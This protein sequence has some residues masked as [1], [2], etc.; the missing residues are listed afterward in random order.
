MPAQLGQTSATV[1]GEHSFFSSLQREQ[2][3]E[4]Y[5]KVGQGKFHHRVHVLQ[6]AK[7]YQ[8]WV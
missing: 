8:P 6:F 5:Y 7:K 3:P 2:W 4:K 1:G